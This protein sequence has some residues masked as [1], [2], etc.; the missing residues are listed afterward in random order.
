MIGSEYRLRAVHAAA[1][2]G[3]AELVHVHGYQPAPPAGPDRADAWHDRP[4]HLAP[5][6]CGLCATPFHVRR[7]L[8]AHT[9]GGD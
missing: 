1:V 6:R 2:G 5:F 3:L 4:M 8:E 7:H 9:C